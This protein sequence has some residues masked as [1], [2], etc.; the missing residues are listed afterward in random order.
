MKMLSY[1]VQKLML[2]L[3]KDKSCSF[4]SQ[5]IFNNQQSFNRVVRILLRCK[6]I[7]ETLFGNYEYGLTLRGL[8]VAKQIKVFMDST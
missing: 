8:D 4:K 7:R 5:E 2:L 1:E 6:W 3:L